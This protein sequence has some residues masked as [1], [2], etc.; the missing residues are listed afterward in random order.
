MRSVILEFFH[1]DEQR[2]RLDE[3]FKDLPT[4]EDVGTMFPQN[5]RIC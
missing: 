1:V 5:V 3:V 2:D 4:F